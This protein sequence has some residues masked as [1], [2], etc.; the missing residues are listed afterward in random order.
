MASS[1]NATSLGEGYPDPLA[2][3]RPHLGQSSLVML[4]VTLQ[5]G[6]QNYTRMFI[7]LSTRTISVSNVWHISL[8]VFIEIKRNIY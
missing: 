2:S 1:S 3:V 7:S 8:H 5:D 6:A 4:T